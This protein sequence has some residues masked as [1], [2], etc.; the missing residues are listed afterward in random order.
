MN[1]P[2]S[3]AERRDFERRIMSLASDCNHVKSNFMQGL[4]QEE[5]SPRF[6]RYKLVAT[7]CLELFVELRSRH[8]SCQDMLLHNESMEIPNFPRE[9]SFS[10]IPFALSLE[11]EHLADLSSWMGST[12]FRAKPNKLVPRGFL[13]ETKN[14]IDK[15]NFHYGWLKPDGY[16]SPEFHAD[17]KFRDAYLHE[18][19]F[20]DQVRSCITNIIDSSRDEPSV[21]LN[22]IKKIH[23]CYV[24][25][26]IT[27]AQ[28]KKRLAHELSVAPVEGLDDLR[29]YILGQVQPKGAECSQRCARMLSSIFDNHPDYD[30]ES[31]AFVM[32][33]N[34]QYVKHAF[35]PDFTREILEHHM[36]QLSEN[37]AG[38]YQTGVR[39]ARLMV[40]LFG[41]LG[42]ST[43]DLCKIAMGAVA[44]F[45]HGTMLDLEPEGAVTQMR[46]V[47]KTIHQF[48]QEPLSLDD[49]LGHA[50]LS[51]VVQSL[52][53]DLVLELSQDSDLQRTQIY[54]ITGNGAHL[55]GMKDLKRLD[56]V[57]A[58]DLG[59]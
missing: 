22:W 17:G 55:A 37:Q 36:N 58:T 44:R 24:R 59:I 12:W 40:R 19:C 27:G 5:S 39:D 52:P 43:S 15:L 57:M 13:N 31:D 32:A 54:S 10:I 35:V 50:V 34:R 23:T 25:D 9:L 20:S 26:P 49:D 33:S 2:L 7:Q 41:I 29:D 56:A 16:K 38:N 6:R 47:F 3:Q 48:N 8:D 21:T 1:T 53:D 30:L 42:L 46:T 14:L 4:T 51:A 45:N 11:S 28:I 18:H